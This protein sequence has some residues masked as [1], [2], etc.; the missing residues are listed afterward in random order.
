LPIFNIVAAAAGSDLPYEFYEKLL[1]VRDGYGY[2]TI[3]D[4]D[5]VYIKFPGCLIKEP[6]ELS[7]KTISQS[8]EKIFKFTRSAPYRLVQ[9]EGV[10][11]EWLNPFIDRWQPVFS[12]DIPGTCTRFPEY[13]SESNS[14]EVTDTKGPITYT[15]KDPC[16]TKSYYRIKKLENQTFE[17]QSNSSP[18]N[19][20]EADWKTIFSA[21]GIVDGNFVTNYRLGLHLKWR[22]QFYGDQL[23]ILDN[24]DFQKFNNPT[25]IWDIKYSYCHADTRVISCRDAPGRPLRYEL[26]E[27]TNKTGE[28]DTNLDGF[29]QFADVQLFYVPNSL[30]RELPLDSPFRLPG[31]D[32]PVSFY[33]IGTLEER[34]AKPTLAYI[35]GGP[36]IT[37]FGEFDATYHALARYFNLYVIE[38]RGSDSR[39]G[40]AGSGE[41]LRGDIGGG[42]VR[43]VISVLRAMQQKTHHKFT[44][45]DRDNI[46]LAGHSF[47][48]FLLAKIM[49]DYTT[50]I[51]RI[52]GFLLLSPV[53]DILG[54]GKFS[55]S[56]YGGYC[57]NYMEYLF[58]AEVLDTRNRGKSVK[59]SD[60]LMGQ[61]AKAN[62]IVSP[63]QNIDKMP[64]GLKSL[65]ITPA[66]DGNVSVEESMKLYIE[67]VRKIAP[68]ALDS[69]PEVLSQLDTYD[70]VNE[71]WKFSRTSITTSKMLSA[72]NEWR[73]QSPQLLQLAIQMHLVEGAT[74]SYKD[75]PEILKA[76]IEKIRDFAA[77]L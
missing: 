71:E 64:T 11:I 58:R 33:Q 12:E 70:T 52:K 47:G 57:N 48:G 4:K 23:A 41:Y 9:K 50:D 59:C 75:N 74:H 30:D 27:A 44:D 40:E 46:I 16:K 68:A 51:E 28:Y 5:G 2:S 62:L 7:R 25:N 6:H 39:M 3:I 38:Y 18:Q 65:I 42:V 15:I 54:M 20:N 14:F 69:V 26:W 56:F 60:E 45:I 8:N 17:I 77:S 29:D 24:P 66:H 35:K 31:I 43:D 32:I 34:S 37:K 13:F 49:Q 53:L 61:L 76:Y 10:A 55:G 63:A 21:Q 19:A 72:F 36:V 22:S 67:W 1:A 73:K